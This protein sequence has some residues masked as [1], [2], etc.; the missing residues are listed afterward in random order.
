MLGGIWESLCSYFDV[1]KGLLILPPSPVDKM[2]HRGL[3]HCCV[4][5]REIVQD[6]GHII[7][8]NGASFLSCKMGLRYPFLV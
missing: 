6:V 2:P 1:C 8:A 3:W 5:P 7:H 4:P